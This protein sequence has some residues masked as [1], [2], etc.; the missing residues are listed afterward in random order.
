[1]VVV[2]KKHEFNINYFPLSIVKLAF[3]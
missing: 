2:L 1:M 3:L